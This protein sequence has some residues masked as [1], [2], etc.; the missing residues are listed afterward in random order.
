MNLVGGEPALIDQHHCV[1]L[2]RHHELSLQGCPVADDFKASEGG[3]DPFASLT[4]EVKHLAHRAHARDNVLLGEPV[5]EL[6]EDVGY[7]VKRNAVD[8]SSRI[9][10]RGWHRDD[11]LV[12]CSSEVH[13]NQ[14][15]L[16][17]GR[18]IGEENPVLHVRHVAAE[19]VLV[20]EG[21]IPVGWLLVDVVRLNPI[22][23]KGV[24]AMTIAS[25][26]VVHPGND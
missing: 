20:L 23:S 5:M 2:N 10:L 7:W 22:E 4:S 19:A 6:Q 18:Q 25:M 1:G 11:Q 9:D 21:W 3:V 8:G 24:W 17:M 15:C 16:L 13:Q 12:S 26:A 14:G